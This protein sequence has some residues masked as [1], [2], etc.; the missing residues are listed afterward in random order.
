MNYLILNSMEMI[1][2]MEAIE[3]EN[4]IY[5]SKMRLYSWLYDEKE[6]QPKYLKELIHNKGKLLPINL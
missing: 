2:I 3:A 4:E 6:I 1:T 5:E